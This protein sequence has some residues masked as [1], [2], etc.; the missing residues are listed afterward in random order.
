MEFNPKT[1]NIRDLGQVLKTRREHQSITRPNLAD[2][3]GMSPNTIRRLEMESRIPTS[4]LLEKI[5]IWLDIDPEEVLL[6]T[7]PTIGHSF[8]KVVKMMRL[9]RGY[10]RVEDLG[11]EI[12]LSGSTIRAVE[13]GK[14]PVAPDTFV[15][16]WDWLD[17]R[18][19]VPITEKDEPVVFDLKDVPGLDEPDKRPGDEYDG[20]KAEELEPVNEYSIR[21]WPPQA[22][23]VFIDLGTVKITV[24][25][26]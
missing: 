24:D 7:R 16:L 10:L 14:N 3:L 18:N 1:F 19:M 8:G 12:G 5:L 17:E 9:G 21:P 6:P 22:R 15:K 20:M 2:E 11:T 23:R 26:E 13:S 4:H 25:L